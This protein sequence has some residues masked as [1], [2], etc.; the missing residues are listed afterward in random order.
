MSLEKKLVS[1]IP[2]FILPF[3]SKENTS[4]VSDKNITTELA[5]IFALSEKGREKP[6]R[7]LSRGSNE[8]ITFISKI[9]YPLWLFSLGDDIFLFDGLNTSEYDLTYATIAPVNDFLEGLKSSS[10][11]RESYASYLAHHTEY[12]SKANKESTLQLKG[13]IAESEMLNE[14]S[15]HCYEASEVKDQ[16]ID[17]GLLSSPLNE[18]RI[19]ATIHEIVQLKAKLEKDI[20]ELGESIDFL[21]KSLKSFHPELQDEID[22]IKHQFGLEISEEEA[23]VA[24][25]VRNIRR[26]YDNR[27][28]S[29]TKMIEKEQ[30]PLHKEK[31]RLINSQ[32]ELNRDVQKYT[33][34]S[35]SLADEED[36]DIWEQ[37]I[38]DA[39]DELCKIDKQL[40][41]NEHDIQTLD[42]KRESETLRHKSDLEA[43]IKAARK[44]ILDLEASRD[45]KILVVKQEME[46]LSSET[47]YL[48][49]QLHNLVKLREADIA[50]L[51]KLSIKPYSEELD[52]ALVYLPFYVIRFDKDAKNRYAI[53][54]PSTMGTMALSTKLKGALGGSRI[55]SLFI[56]RFKQ[57]NHLAEN[58]KEQSEKNSVFEQEL[59]ALGTSNNI[60]A[61]TWI[62]D[63]IER[64]LLT[65][66]QRGWLNDKEYGSA[67]ESFKTTLKRL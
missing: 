46:K 38:D 66:K 25:L 18:S 32:Q 16:L 21:G 26:E 19:T 67:M 28:I 44:E 62:S 55:K 2:K 8:K 36:K 57:L 35:K 34:K 59:K 41:K 13:L 45:A 43:E 50:Q 56:P 7:I 48:I 33:T 52:K 15:S 58:I 10:R 65:L 37:K 64:G 14:F 1:E 49:D 51:K 29:L 12:F 4:S 39:K 31:L 20:D 40:E 47:K 27:I 61:M 53:V 11:K 30:V 60:L 63:E 23:A 6:G 24:P 9:G 54:S 3:S 5:A 22:A 17:I 42:K